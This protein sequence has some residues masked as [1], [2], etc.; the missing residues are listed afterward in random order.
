MAKKSAKKATTKKVATKKAATKKKVTT[1]KASAK[2]A[3]KKV[4]AKKVAAKKT[5]KAAVKKVKTAAKKATTKKTATKKKVA[6]KRKTATKVKAQLKEVVFN[7]YSPDSKTVQVAGEFNSWDPAKG[8]LKKDK[9]GN[10]TLKVKLA[11]GTY[12][13]KIVYDGQYWELDQS[14][15]SVMAE[16]GPNSVVYVD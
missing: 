16:H 6:T 3:A 10:W 13:Y 2:A 12:Q 5:V 11:P 8:K 15:E 9:E 14:A 1:K 4:V 7:V